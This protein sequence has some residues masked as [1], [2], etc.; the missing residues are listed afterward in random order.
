VNHWTFIIAA[1][2]ITIVGA[3]GVTLHSYLVMRRAERRSDSLRDR[4]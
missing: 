2:A 3:V 1:Y 4:P